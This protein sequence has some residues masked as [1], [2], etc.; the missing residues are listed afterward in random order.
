MKKWREFFKPIVY[1]VVMQ[2]QLLFVTQMKTALNTNINK[3]I[4]WVTRPM[5][6]KKIEYL[7]EWYMHASKS[8]LSS[9]CSR[10]WSSL[11]EKAEALGTRLRQT[12]R[13]NG[14]VK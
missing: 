6:Q 13:T 2:N 1:S 12:A 11:T 10:V 8:S 4:V 3:V 7:L 5:L 9:V 14:R